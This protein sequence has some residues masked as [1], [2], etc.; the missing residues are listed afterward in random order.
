M[1][2]LYI[3]EK[4]EK[5]EKEKKREQKFYINTPK[6][7]KNREKLANSYQKRLN[8][9]IIETIKNKNENIIIKDYK[10]PIFHP[11][12]DYQKE[13]EN[14]LNDK[15]GF[16]FKNKKIEL[17][18]IEHHNLKKNKS[19]T[20]NNSI[21]INNDSNDLNFNNSEINF[22]N[23]LNSII[24]KDYIGDKNNSKFNKDLNNFDNNFYQKYFKNKSDSELIKNNCNNS[25]EEI[26]SK[27]LKEINL[28]PKRKLTKM[29]S[30]IRKR[31]I[32]NNQLILNKNLTPQF[33]KK[34]SYN[35]KF[36]SILR[37]ANNIL[38]LSKNNSKLKKIKEKNEEN[39]KI[40]IPKL[41]YLKFKNP[42]I[43]KEKKDILGDINELKKFAFDKSFFDTNKETQNIFFSHIDLI[44]WHLEHSEYGIPQK[45]KI[46]IGNHEYNIKKDM[47]ILAMEVL[48]KYNVVKINKDKILKE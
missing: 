13:N 33:Q 37:V 43:I 39:K 10:T 21:N 8:E 16:Y 42:N 15:K 11:R 35:T 2:N 32:N 40:K 5:E 36:K 25:K 30:L 48:G 41:N 1:F 9:Y 38:D 12:I 26:K 45:D 7:L 29:N 4:Q 34:K 44:N 3:K 47:N 23:I 19:T 28:F 20:S 6:Y 31:N 18:R 17:E 24:H 27:F 46:I 14:K 22:N